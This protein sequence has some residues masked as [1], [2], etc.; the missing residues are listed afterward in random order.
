[1]RLFLRFSALALGAALAACG[2]TPKLADGG[3]GQIVD[4][5]VAPFESPAATRNLAEDL[6]AKTLNAAYRFSESGPGKALFVEV[7]QVQTSRPD[8]AYLVSTGANGIVAEVSMTDLRTGEAVRLR[9]VS[10][11]SFRAAGLIGSQA[12][13]EGDPVALEQ[14]LA[15]AL[16]ENIM[17]RIYGED[18]AETVAERAP[19]KTAA[20]RYPYSYAV[21]RERLECLRLRSRQEAAKLDAAVRS[22]VVGDDGERLPAHCAK[23]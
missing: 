7:V 12:A 9:P 11:R 1:M 4:V 14:A 6:R 22:W 18:Y 19:S 5:E 10:A 21:E 15:S 17:R 20:A 13:D 8:E 2:M 23:Y 16:A 3:A